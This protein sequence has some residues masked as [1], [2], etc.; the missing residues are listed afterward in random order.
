MG[1]ERPGGLPSV[2]ELRERPADWSLIALLFEAPGPEWRNRLLEAGAATVDPE[3][4]AAVEVAQREGQEYFHGCLFGEDG[5]LIVRES[6]YREQRHREPLIADL[7]GLADATGFTRFPAESADH[8]GS[9]VA[10]MAHLAAQESEAAA[11]GR[12][13]EA[14]YLEGAIEWLRRA[15]LAWF[16]K[17]LSR[18]LAETEVCYLSH[19]AHALEARVHPLGEDEGARQ[20]P[21]DDAAAAELMD[22]DS[23][24]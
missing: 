16:V 1:Q 4:R 13:G 15:H 14:F 21:S 17:Q 22:R 24:G 11:D 8:I 2:I 9:L 3:L 18:A 5:L 7:H 23:N 6:A 10:F 20:R 12:V 19:V